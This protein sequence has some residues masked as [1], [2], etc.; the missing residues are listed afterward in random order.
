MTDASVDLAPRYLPAGY[1][2]SGID[3]A[4]FGGFTGLTDQVTLIYTTNEGA[5]EPHRSLQVHFT[6]TRGQ[7]LVATNRRQA[8]IIDLDGHPGHYHDGITTLVGRN[9]DGSA[10]VR[11]QNLAHSI[12]VSTSRGTFAV[13]APGELPYAE[14]LAV[15]RSLPL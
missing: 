2:E 15:T 14:L 8:R 5:R 10:L 11:W 12:T 13:R 3:P 6:P 9:A 1:H 7:E 4:P